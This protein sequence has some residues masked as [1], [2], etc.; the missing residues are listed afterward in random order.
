MTH[1]KRRT[2]VQARNLS[3]ESNCFLFILFLTVCIVWL[4]QVGL[5]S[6]WMTHYKRRTHVQARNLS[7]EYNCFLFVLW[8]FLSFLWNKKNMI[9]YWWMTLSCLFNRCC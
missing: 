7:V 3:V 8:Y 9:N 1:Y 4:A 2:H 5:F 6:G